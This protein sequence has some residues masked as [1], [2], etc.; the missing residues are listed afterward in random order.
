MGEAAFGG[1]GEQRFA[2]LA[3]ISLEQYAACLREA[4]APR[5]AAAGCAVEAALPAA[6]IA[7]LQ[8]RVASQPRAIELSSTVSGI[9]AVCAFVEAC[10][11]SDTPLA[12]QLA[13]CTPAQRRAYMEAEI[14]R[15]V[16]ELLGDAGCA[17]SLE[18]FFEPRQL[19]PTAWRTLRTEVPR[20][21]THHGGSVDTIA[22]ELGSMSFFAPTE[23]SP[24]LVS[25]LHQLA[26]SNSS[27]DPGLPMS[28]PMLRDYEMGAFH[29]LQVFH[30]DEGDESRSGSRELESCWIHC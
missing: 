19:K 10:G 2:G 27:V 11:A 26:R 12:R 8:Q 4:L 5:S 25:E 6:T 13:Q 21:I 16:A 17:L 28:E 22:L 9:Q 29:V 24:A 30:M 14:L 7:E 3:F 18:R 20:I 23:R 1:R 15:V